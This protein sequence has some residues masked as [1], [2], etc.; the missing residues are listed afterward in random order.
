MVVSFLKGVKCPSCFS[1]SPTFC[2]SLSRKGIAK[3][4]EDD[5]DDEPDHKTEIKE[6]QDDSEDSDN[7]A[8]RAKREDAEDL[9]RKARFNLEKLN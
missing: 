5:D 1:F 3:K 6:G 8:N 4:E 7:V 2:T 9:V